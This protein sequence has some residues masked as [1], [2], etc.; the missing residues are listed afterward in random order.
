M[1]SLGKW[2]NNVN[3]ANASRHGCSFGDYA[4][5]PSGYSEG[6]GIIVCP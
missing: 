2:F 4:P 5:K 3:A 1:I 6:D